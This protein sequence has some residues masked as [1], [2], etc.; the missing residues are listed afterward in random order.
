MISEWKQAMRV[1]LHALEENGTWSLTTLPPGKRDV[2]CKWVYKLKFWAY[3]SLEPHKAL[4]VA[5]GYTQQEGVDYID[6]FSPIA[7]PVTVKLLLALAAI[8]DWCLVQLDVNNAFLQGDLTEEV[9]MSLP[10]GYPH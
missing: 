1:E 2:G 8:Y 5:K 6:T 4:L 10:Q 7:K 3:G 9:Y